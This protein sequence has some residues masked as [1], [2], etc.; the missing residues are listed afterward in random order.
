M[1]ATNR[2]LVKR[3]DELTEALAEVRGNVKEIAD[4]HMLAEATAEADDIAEYID[5]VIGHA[6]DDEDAE[7]EEGEYFEES[8]EELEGEE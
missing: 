8:D 7:E 4:A 5:A 6:E 2:M 3:V 1:G